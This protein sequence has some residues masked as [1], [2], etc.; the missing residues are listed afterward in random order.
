MERETR[1]GTEKRREIRGKKRK[2]TRPEIVTEREM[3]TGAVKRQEIRNKKRKRNENSDRNRK[4]KEN[5][6]K[7]TTGPEQR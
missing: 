2:E 6:I 1:P 4:R 5:R 7:K 3:R